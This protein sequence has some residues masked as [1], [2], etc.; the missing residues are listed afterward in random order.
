MKTLFYST[1]PFEKSHFESVAHQHEFDFTNEKLSQETATLADEHKAVC[2]F[3]SD[4]ADKKVLTNLYKSGV[5]YLVLRSAGYDH[6]DLKF[7]RE[8]GMRVARVPA[9][10]P[11][12]VAEHSIALMMALNRKLIKANTQ[13]QR[14]DFRLDNLIGFDMH[15]KTAG[16][17]GLGKIG[18]VA[19]T[20]LN[21][22][23]CRVLGYD[24][25]NPELD[26]VEWVSLDKLLAESDIIS[27]YIPATPET[28][29]LI[30]H[31]TIE[32]MK[33][34][35]MLINTGRGVLVD[36][37][38]LINGIQSGKIGYA[39]LDVYEYEKSL[40][41]EDHSQKPL[42]DKLLLKL[43]SFDNV[44]LTGHQAFLT[45]E[46]LGNITET[47]LYNLTAF[48]TGIACENEL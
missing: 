32:K 30:N 31:D 1:K 18:K 13:F 4:I 41:F 23:G 3:T 16:I 29:H 34:G 8:M 44:L 37:L 11:Y 15:G 35:V 46:A 6:V 14:N 38:D 24:I 40:Y 2:L 22:F 9:Y 26:Y 25:V 28:R 42:E 5:R 20:I 27:L 21:G 43:Q 47:T 19:A 12:S 48:E 45:E 17:I 39:G 36:T 33:R 7:A 10:S